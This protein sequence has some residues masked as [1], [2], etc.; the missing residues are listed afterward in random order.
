MATIE[1]SAKLHLEEEK[2]NEMIQY[3]FTLNFDW[4]KHVIKELYEGMQNQGKEIELLRGTCE[5]LTGGISI[6]DYA[7]GSNSNKPA[8][9]IGLN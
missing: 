1:K 7:S 9:Q 8:L 6:E 3:S 4:L 2:L 5:T